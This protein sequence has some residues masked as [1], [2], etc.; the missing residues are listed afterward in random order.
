MIA[1][2]NWENYRSFLE[3][4]FIAFSKSAVTTKSSANLT[5][6]VDCTLFVVERLTPLDS[7]QALLSRDLIFIN[8]LPSLSVTAPTLAAWKSPSTVQFISSGDII[9]PCHMTLLLS[10]A[11][12]IIFY[13]HVWLKTGR[14]LC[15]IRLQHNQVVLRYLFKLSF[16]LYCTELLITRSIIVVWILALR[17]DL[18]WLVI[19]TFFK[20]NSWLILSKQPLMSASSTYLVKLNTRPVFDL[21]WSAC[22]FAL[23]ISLG[24]NLVLER[25]PLSWDF[26]LD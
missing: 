2:S 15:G 7:K 26:Y 21:C 14:S 20:S 16:F 19:G 23:I 24:M 22:I 13:L 25:P 9:P 10:S 12:H 1:L 6:W 11:L 8:K 17:S 5:K 3:H 18:Y 4:F